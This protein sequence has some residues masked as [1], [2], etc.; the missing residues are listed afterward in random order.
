MLTRIFLD[1]ILN[2][3]GSFKEKLNSQY[4]G[5]QMTKIRRA[6]EGKKVAG[7]CQGIANAF[8][9]NVSYVRLAWVLSALLPMITVFGAAAFYALLAF[10]LPEDEDYID[11]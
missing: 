5:I 10:I 1:I 7:V 2:Q 6:K 3:E 8:D 4:G 9:I 11:V